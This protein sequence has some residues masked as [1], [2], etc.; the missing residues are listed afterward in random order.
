MFGLETHTHT[1]TLWGCRGGRG[2]D[3]Q[4]GWR[5]FLLFFSA[6]LS[7]DLVTRPLCLGQIGQSF[8]TVG[9][10]QVGPEAPWGVPAEGFLL[11]KFGG[12]VNDSHST[13]VPRTSRT[14][15][16]LAKGAAGVLVT[17]QVGQECGSVRVEV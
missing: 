16:P 11:M 5:H 6:T 2:D 8:L 3:Y 4:R 7:P 15:W 14:P 17:D 1:H 12:Q 13:W 9:L 10:V